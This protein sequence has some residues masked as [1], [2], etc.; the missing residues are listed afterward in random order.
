MSFFF[1]VTYTH[2]YIPVD[3]HTAPP[4]LRAPIPP[5]LAKK[6]LEYRRILLYIQSSSWRIN[7]QYPYLLEAGRGFRAQGCKIPS[8]H[9]L[10]TRSKCTK[11]ISAHMQF[12]IAT[13]NLVFRSQG[14]P[15]FL[16][17]I[18]KNI[19]TKITFLSLLSA[20]PSPV[21]AS[22]PCREFPPAKASVVIELL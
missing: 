18:K 21:H 13:K 19:S 16:F 4:P 22:C 3:T 2:T 10:V 20:A 11:Q 12:K 7:A 15:Y 5:S 14:P 8:K 6:K 9:H 1:S 17:F